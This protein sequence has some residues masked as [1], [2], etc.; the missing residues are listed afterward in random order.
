M[1]VVMVATLGSGVF[2]A[3][4]GSWNDWLLFLYDVPAALL[5][6]SFV[7]STASSAFF[8]PRESETRLRVFLLAPLTIIPVG[9]EFLGWPVSGHLADVLTI[10]LFEGMHVRASWPKR[11]LAFLPVLIVLPI[12][13][14]SLD[15]AD[16]VATYA[17]LVAGLTLGVAAVVL[18]RILQQASQGEA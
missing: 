15:S 17:G 12:R 7:G 16:H 4:S 5:V 6:F 18:S 8:A 3:Y 2:V 9:R 10:A 13:W 14:F 11:V 1:F